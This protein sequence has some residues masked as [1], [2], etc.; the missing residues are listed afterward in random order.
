M[1]TGAVDVRV[2]G[3][4]P[5]LA[6]AVEPEVLLGDHRRVTEDRLR[7]GD[8][9]DDVL[10]RVGEVARGGDEEERLRRRGAARRQD[11]ERDPVLRVSLEQPERV[12]A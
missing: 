9:V 6:V 12:D 7:D 2:V 5:E 3:R 8:V 11:E 10:V 1:D 4:E